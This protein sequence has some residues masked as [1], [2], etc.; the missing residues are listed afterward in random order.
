VGRGRGAGGGGGGGGELFIQRTV[1]GANASRTL[2]PTA[3]PLPDGCKAGLVKCG[4]SGCGCAG[5]CCC[6]DREGVGK[7]S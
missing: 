5:S 1:G 2:I 6:G 3:P 7:G 4:G